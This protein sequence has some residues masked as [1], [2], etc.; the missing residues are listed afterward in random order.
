MPGTSMAEA[1]QALSIRS[2]IKPF[3]KGL[4]RGEPL[5][6]VAIFALGREIPREERL[7]YAE[8]LARK[9]TT[10]DRVLGLLKMERDDEVQTTLG[11]AYK[12]SFENGLRTLKARLEGNL[13]VGQGKS[14]LTDLMFFLSHAKMQLVPAVEATWLRSHGTKDALSKTLERCNREIMDLENRA[15]IVYGDK[16]S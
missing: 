3:F 16:K 1:R 8:R 2:R 14:N 11:Q 13:Q 12:K 6:E 7:Q 4:A 5:V 9:G 15:R 10:I